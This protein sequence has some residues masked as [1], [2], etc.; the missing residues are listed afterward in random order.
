MP[1]PAQEVKH[2]PS[3]VNHLIV[4]QLMAQTRAKTLLSFLTT[5]LAC[6]TK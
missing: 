2:H 5:E 1:P 4:Q 6:V 3:S